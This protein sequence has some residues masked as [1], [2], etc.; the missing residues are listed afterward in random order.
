[1]MTDRRMR[2]GAVTILCFLGV[3]AL[4]ASLATV[5]T[6]GVSLPAVALSM[7]DPVRP[8]LAGLLLLAVA[9]AS[10]TGAD[11]AR[12]TRLYAGTAAQM[13]ARGAAVIAAGVLVFSIAWTS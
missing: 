6:G 10:T 11:F 7:R 12:R 9:R 1:M 3:L 13:P 2:G 5:L 4:A 8:L